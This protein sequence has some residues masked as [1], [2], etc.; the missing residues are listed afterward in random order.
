MTSNP[1]CRTNTEALSYRKV[2]SIVS[3]SKSFWLSEL[4]VILDKHSDSATKREAS[5]FCNTE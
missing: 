3:N 1:A 2:A 4:T 5:V